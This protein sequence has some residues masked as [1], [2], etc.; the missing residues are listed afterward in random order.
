MNRLYRVSQKADLG[1]EFYQLLTYTQIVELYK[2][3]EEDREAILQ[4]LPGEEFDSDSIDLKV[5]LTNEIEEEEDTDD[6][7]W[8]NLRF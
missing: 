1:G 3:F 8:Y 7:D 2:V 5:V 4:L 6:D